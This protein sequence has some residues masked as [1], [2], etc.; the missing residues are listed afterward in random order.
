[1]EYLQQI[2]KEHHNAQNLAK[3]GYL[4]LY[5]AIGEEIF[6]FS[7][8]VIDRANLDTDGNLVVELDKVLDYK[9]EM[10]FKIKALLESYNAE[11]LKWRVEDNEE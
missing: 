5:K 6:E 3:D 11:C 2:L 7:D 1:M 8:K 10:L 4:K 9:R